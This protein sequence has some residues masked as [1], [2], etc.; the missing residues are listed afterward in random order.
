MRELTTSIAS[1]MVLSVHIIRACCRLHSTISL[2]RI[3]DQLR[4]PLLSLG[5]TSPHFLHFF[6]SPHTAKRYEEM[7]QHHRQE[8]F[9]CSRHPIGRATYAE[10]SLSRHRHV[11]KRR[12]VGGLATEHRTSTSACPT[13]NPLSLLDHAVSQ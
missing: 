9:M 2:P 4:F 5:I 12:T 1:R 10:S 7:C 8:K 11:S 13:Q 3:F 6:M